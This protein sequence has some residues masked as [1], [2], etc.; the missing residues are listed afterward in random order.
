MNDVQDSNIDFSDL[1]GKWLWVSTTG[2][3]AGLSTTPESTGNEVIIEF[4]KDHHFKKYVNQVAQ[5]N[6]SCQVIMKKSIFS[7]DLTPQLKFIG[8]DI[9]QTIELKGNELVL[10]EECYDCYQHVYMKQ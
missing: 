6:D 7:T 1:Q 10:K 9:H 4:T 5:V 2:G 8:E 3:F